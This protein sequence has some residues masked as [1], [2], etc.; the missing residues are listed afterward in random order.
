MDRTHDGRVSRFP[1]G[2]SVRLYQRCQLTSKRAQCCRRCNFTFRHAT[3]WRFVQTL[4]T[5]EVFYTYRTAFVCQSFFDGEERRSL[6]RKRAKTDE[7]DLD[8]PN[9]KI[10]AIKLDRIWLDENANNAIPCFLS[11]MT[12]S[13]PCV[14][15][16]FWT[17]SYCFVHS[18]RQRCGPN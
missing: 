2:G 1:S 18:H 17:F 13:A 8:N 7:F 14:D 12:H 9:S 3:N 16:K 6:I 15:R 5:D 10:L 11:R 4:I